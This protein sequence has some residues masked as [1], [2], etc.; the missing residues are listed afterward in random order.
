MTLLLLP[1][2]AMLLGVAM[3]QLLLATLAPNLSGGLAPW[4]GA[5]SDRIVDLTLATRRIPWLSIELRPV[6]LWAGVLVG[7]VIL[8]A[9]FAPRLHLRRRSAAALVL[10]GMAVAGIATQTSARPTGQGELAVLDVG[11]GQCAA[12]RTPGGR[13][14]LLD[15]GSRSQAD[16]Y[17]QTL[18]PFLQHRR[19]PWPAA[20]FISHGDA[21]HYNAL[22]S[23]VDL[24]PPRAVFSNERFG[25]ESD[26]ASLLRRLLED[27]ADHGVKPRQLSRGQRIALDK[28]CAVTVLWPPA[29]AAYGGLLSNDACLVLR[30]ECAGTRVLLPGDIEQLAEQ[31]LLELSP[32]ELRAEVLVLPHHGGATSNLDAFIAAVDPAIIIRSGDRRHAPTAE[33]DA[34]VITHHDFFST[35]RCGA[36]TVN[37]TGKGP[38]V[39]PYLDK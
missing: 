30:L 38:I 29:S 31:L 5:A 17:G 26:E 1:L 37:F 36:I 33:G 7:A 10:L 22:G 39:G 11:H 16:P 12:F 15:A 3:A 23:L 4:L 6:P 9:A 27:L 25:H 24:Q 14:F 13:V 21:D 2:V 8:I 34:A 32:Q 18:L 35:D 20:A 28:D 19:W